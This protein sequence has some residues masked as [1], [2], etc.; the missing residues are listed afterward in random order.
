MVT[1][2]FDLL[3][4]LSIV[5]DVVN[6]CLLLRRLSRAGSQDS[7]CILRTSP[8]P[9]E[10]LPCLPDLLAYGTQAFPNNIGDVGFKANKDIFGEEKA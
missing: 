4:K 8:D 10:F 3:L 1:S 9:H 7:I 6:R 5:F 2:C